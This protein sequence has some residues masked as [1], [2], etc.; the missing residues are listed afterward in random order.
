[1]ASE[2][3]LLFAENRYSFAHESLFDYSFARRFSA[4]GRNLIDLLVNDDQRLFRRAQVRQ[5]LTFLRG[6]D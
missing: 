1:M 2:H 4:K 5:I 3:F 6:Q